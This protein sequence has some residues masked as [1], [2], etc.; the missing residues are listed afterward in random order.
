MGLVGVRPMDTVSDGRT[1]GV[2]SLTTTDAMPQGNHHV[3]TAKESNE[4]QQ[5]EEEEENQKK[6]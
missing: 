3:K 1:D 4:R 2:D 6:L 5:Q